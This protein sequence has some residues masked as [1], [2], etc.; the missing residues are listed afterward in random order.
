M[1]AV[2]TLVQD[3]AYAAQ[4]LGQDQT[5]SSGDAQ[6]ILRRLN[7]MLDSWSNEK[8]MVFVND[9]VSFQM[10]AGV[11]TYSTAMLSSGR[12]IAINAMTVLLSNIYYNVD[13]IDVLKWNQITYKITQSVPNQ[14]YYN[15]SY[16]DG[17]MNFYPT[18]YAAF[19]C[20]VDCQYP[21]TGTLTLATDLLLPE[22]YEAAIVAALAV[23]IWGSFKTGVP[24]QAMM[25]EMV[26]TRAVLKRNNFV[27]MEM[28]TPFDQENGDI[29]N[30][31]LY[32]GF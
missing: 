2:A 15:A 12:P 28:D 32:K 14:C 13:M 9:T 4:V 26:D 7:R 27:P 21:L 3:A 31:F 29:S 18:P 16:P 1:T 8:Q 22:G 5:I 11:A 6:L 30:A 19:T 25:K 10:T 17:Q 20:N 24:T 23:N